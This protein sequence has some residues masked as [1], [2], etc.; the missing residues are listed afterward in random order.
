MP[1]A[2]KPV[3]LLILDGWGL[4]TDPQNSAIDLAHTPTWD[5]LWRDWPH[6]RLIP[7]GTH[8]GLMEGQMGNSEVGHLNLGAGRIVRQDLL[9]LFRLIRDGELATH[10]AL[11]AFLAPLA[12]N[13]GTLH[14]VGLFS[15]GGVHSHIEHLVG[16]AQQAA[17]AGVQRIAIHALTDGRDTAPH[18]AEQYFERAARELPDNA[19][20]AT[21]GGRYYL[22]DRDHRWERTQQHWDVITHG[23]GPVAKDWQ[24]AMAAARGRDEGDE[25]ITPTVLGDYAGFAAN[26]RIL[27]FNFR[28][29]RMRQ[30]V[31]AWSQPEF[32]EFERGD[33]TVLPLF[34]VRRYES[35]FDNPVL[36]TRDTVDETLAQLLSR[37]GMT[38]YK[39]AETEKYAHVTYFFNGG[40]EAPWPGEDRVLVPSPKVAT[41]DLQPQM[42][43]NEVTDRL[44]AD[45]R[46]SG[47]DL[48]VVNFANGDMV[49]HTGVK[50]AC[51]AA[52]EA[53]DSCLARVMEAAQ[54]GERISVIVTADHGNC[55]V[56]SWPDGSPHTQHS[57]NDSPLVL[58]SAPRREL[59]QPQEW[60]LRDVAP[61]VI[62]LLGIQQPA[63]WDGTSLLED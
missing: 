53:V 25:F 3:L 42:S 44:V 62:E 38:T 61:T 10:P 13:G 54:W 17:A 49:G 24:T 32:S 2:D 52:C 58:V 11:K 31:E 43:V 39:S 47:H 4:G 63:S 8:V 34:S 33:Y 5:R 40:M 56:L 28:A 35:H 12:D 23:M 48:Y 50:Q 41:Y 51:S 7:H 29:D 45:L 21:L 22:M 46:Q 6:T 20:F 9:E 18:I 59:K 19:F 15:D 16:L 55:D 14:F 30:S 1:R 27:C 57:M 37:H 60:S 36:I 26:D